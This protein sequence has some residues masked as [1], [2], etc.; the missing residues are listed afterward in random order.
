MLKVMD[1]F[2]KLVGICVVVSHLYSVPAQAQS[3]PSKEEVY[4]DCTVRL[5]AEDLPNGSMEVSFKRPAAG[6]PH[7]GDGLEFKFGKH[8]VLAAIDSKWRNLEWQKSGEI[9]A[10]TVSVT[11][12]PYDGPHALILYN[13]KNTSEQLALDCSGYSLKD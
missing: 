2:S 5:I 7:G 13:P 10:S 11:L 4:Y 8:L 1:I 3:L 9:I 6:G 12:N